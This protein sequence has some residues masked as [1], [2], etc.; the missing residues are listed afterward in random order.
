[1]LK[2]VYI[3]P[4]RTAVE[5]ILGPLSLKAC[6]RYFD[7][8]TRVRATKGTVATVESAAFLRK[9]KFA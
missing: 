5:L 7:R 3:L 6:Y 2:F 4:F 1:M 8:K 9:S